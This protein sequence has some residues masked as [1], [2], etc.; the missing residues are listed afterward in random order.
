[1]S[2][3]LTLILVLVL[4]LVVGFPVAPG[5]RRWGLRLTRRGARA[6][7]RARTG[8]RWVARTRRRRPWVDPWLLRRVVWLHAGVVRPRLAVVLV[9]GRMLAARAGSRVGLAVL[10]LRPRRRT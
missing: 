8:A 1:M 5:G 3:R 7:L 2:A 6:R 9:G 4:V 10:L